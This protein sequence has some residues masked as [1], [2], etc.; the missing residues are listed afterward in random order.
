MAL[1]WKPGPNELEGVA[2]ILRTDPL[3]YMA[4]GPYWWWVKRWLKEAYG[5]KAPI[6]GDADDP[7]TRLRLAQ[8]WKRDGKKLWQAAIN[9]FEQ[10][11][12]WGE[13]YEPHSY[14]P[15]WEEGY[16]LYDPDMGVGWW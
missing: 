7:M 2:T 9:H 11:A 13:R 4:F 3:S 6:Q 15:P 12:A 14:L 8:Y 10:K 16:T 1:S 5:D